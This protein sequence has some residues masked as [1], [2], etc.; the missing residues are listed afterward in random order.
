MC[1]LKCFMPEGRKRCVEIV[2]L[3]SV[4]IPHINFKTVEKLLE[5]VQQASHKV[6]PCNKNGTTSQSSWFITIDIFHTRYCVSDKQSIRQ[7]FHFSD[8]RSYSKL[9]CVFLCGLSGWFRWSRWLVKSQKLILMKE[10]EGR[11]KRSQFL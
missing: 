10:M 3:Q 5:P 11:L 7:L 1:Y 4:K 6:L 8:I 2:L 9:I